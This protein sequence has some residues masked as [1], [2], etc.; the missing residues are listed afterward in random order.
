MRERLRRRWFLIVA[1]FAVLLGPT[2][3]RAE[4]QTTSAIVFSYGYDYVGQAVDISS[5][6]GSMTTVSATVSA[7]QVQNGPDRIAVKLLFRNGE[8]QQVH[9]LNDPVQY[10]TAPV[11]WGDITFVAD[12]SAF[13]T[14]SWT[15]MVVEIWGKDGENWGGNYGTAVESISLSINETDT[16]Y[17]RIYHQLH[18]QKVWKKYFRSKK[19]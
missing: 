11:E 10:E 13:D 12:L 2:A 18:R 7:K 3:L 5:F 14:S 9:S 4:A 6:A 1:I 8:G 19:I 17:C 15:E 16:N